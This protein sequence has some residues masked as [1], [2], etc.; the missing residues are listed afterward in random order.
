MPI[1]RLNVEGDN[2]STAE[3]VIAQ[4]TNLQLECYLENWLENSP[5]ALIQDKTI[6]WIRRQPSAA[7]EERLLRKTRWL[8]GTRVDTD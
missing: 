2:L 5:W 1:F 6:L 3:L 8:H 4:E 7:D